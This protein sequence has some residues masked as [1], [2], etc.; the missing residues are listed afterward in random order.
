MASLVNMTAHERQVFFADDVS[1]V[2]GDNSVQEYEE[3]YT[4][5]A[6][7]CGGMSLEEIISS[8]DKRTQHTYLRVP[9]E[10]S[11]LSTKLGRIGTEKIIDEV[12]EDIRERGSVDLYPGI[13]LLAWSL[14]R[15][16]EIDLSAIV[17]K[18]EILQ[19]VIAYCSLDL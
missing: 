4:D 11:C 5:V 16:D 18:R 19:F 7:T 1:I 9:I 2:S 15:S 6:E 3:K 14:A 8:K 10:E 13:V 12:C 17:V